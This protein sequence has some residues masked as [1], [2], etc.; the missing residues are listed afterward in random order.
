[1]KEKYKL[2]LQ[3]KG[4]RTQNIGIKGKIISEMNTKLEGH[5]CLNIMH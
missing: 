2:Q 1:M 3:R 4:E 5:E